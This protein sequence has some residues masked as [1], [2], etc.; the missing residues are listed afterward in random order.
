MS[1]LYREQEAKFWER[2]EREEEENKKQKQSENL[3]NGLQTA[4]E[5]GESTRC[6]SANHGWMTTL[7]KNDKKKNGVPKSSVQAWNH[8]KRI[9]P[10][11]YT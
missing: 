5:S 10:P 4:Q 8:R 7:I 3:Q 9:Y 6:W 2:S 11:S 1:K